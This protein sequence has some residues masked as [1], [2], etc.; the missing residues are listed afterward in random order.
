MSPT[1]IFVRSVSLL[2]RAVSEAARRDDE[3]LVVRT[4]RAPD[5]LDGRALDVRLPALHLRGHA[6]F[7]RVAKDQYAAHVNAAVGG[8]PGNDY[9]L[10]PECDQ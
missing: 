1:G 3:A 4:E 9:V 7:D 10:E 5:L 6:R 8:H 2:S